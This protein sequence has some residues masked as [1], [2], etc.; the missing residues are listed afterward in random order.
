MHPFSKSSPLKS[1]AVGRA[2][3]CLLD[4]DLYHRG[5]ENAEW[6]SELDGFGLGRCSKIPALPSHTNSNLCVL[7]ASAVQSFSHPVT[8]LTGSPPNKTADTFA[9]TISVIISRYRRPP[10]PMCG[11]STTFSNSNNSAVT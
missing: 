7:C 5:A 10:D 9:D 4:D 11:V 6:E 3:P 8:T 2:S 1:L